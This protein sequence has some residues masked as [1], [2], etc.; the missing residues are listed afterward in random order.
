MP[1]IRIKENEIFDI[2]LR[3]FKRMC[4]R[5]GIIAKYKEKLHYEKPT[6]ARKRKKIAAIKRNWRL[7]RQHGLPSSET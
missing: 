2:S 1:T 6:W 5:A 7:Q 4:E 3:K